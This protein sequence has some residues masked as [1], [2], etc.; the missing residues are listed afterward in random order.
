MCCATLHLGG[1]PHT[2]PARLGR[3]VRSV[4]GAAGRHRLQFG[5]TVSA[6]GHTKGLEYTMG[7]NARG[8]LPLVLLILLAW[9]LGLSPGHPWGDDWAG[10]L[11]QARSLVEGDVVREL[12][13]N[14]AAMRDSDVQV[15]PD[16]YPWGYPLLLAVVGAVSDWNLTALKLIGAASALLVLA[17]TYLLGRSSLGVGLAT[18]IAVLVA[19]QPRLLV[20]SSFLGSDYPF[21]ALATLALA[22]TLMQA[23]RRTDGFGWSSRVMVAVALLGT[24]AYAVRSNGLVI[25]ATYLAMVALDAMRQRAAAGAALRH[26]LAF[27]ALSAALLGAYS[28][29]LPDGSLSH[30]QYLSFDPAVWMGRGIRHV[31]YLGTWF[32]F[33]LLHGVPRA[34]AMLPFALL[35]GFALLRRPRECALLVLYMLLH[36]ALITV[37]PFDGG[38]RYY[39]PLM[40]PAFVVFGI[41]VREAWPALATRG[42]PAAAA[43]TLGE[44]AATSPAATVG[45]MLLAGLL[46]GLTW[47]EQRTYASAAADAPYGPAMRDAIAFVDAHAPAG[48]RIAFFKPRAFRLLSGRTAAA[49][50]E[51]DNLG[52]VDW[53][54]FNAMNSEPR[55]QVDESTLTAPDAGFALVHDNGPFRIYAHPARSPMP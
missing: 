18:T 49:I 36:V 25:P 15:G 48:A 38:A 23:R 30:A 47:A 33:A 19:F 5:A 17:A 54:V 12:A 51:P 22:L 42:L 20:E 7:M 26:G 43:A 37:F 13:I 2:G 50:G 16:G 1:R 35:V 45:A 44:S 4:K 52:R 29:A 40:A 24:A 46:V 34:L 32:P 39:F 53:Y 11:L 41:G 6:C 9:Y 14:G 21:V 8:L 28:V 31:M 27:A 10:Y 3:H 55:L